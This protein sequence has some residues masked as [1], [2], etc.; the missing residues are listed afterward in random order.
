VNPEDISGGVP[1]PTTTECVMWVQRLQAQ[2]L[3]AAMAYEG[4]WL[5]NLRG[6]EGLRQEG[7]R[8]V[9]HTFTLLDDESGV[10][11]CILVK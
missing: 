2:H 10:V 9:S 7:Y 3:A 8:I 6:A 5:G 1:E 11:T 4:S